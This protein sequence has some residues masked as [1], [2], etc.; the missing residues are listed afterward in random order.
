MLFGKS[1]RGSAAQGANNQ[2]SNKDGFT[3]VEGPDLKSRLDSAIKAGRASSHEKFW[4]GYSIDLAQGVAVDVTVT[5]PDGPSSYFPWLQ[6]MKEPTNGY[7]TRN[8]GVFV[9]FDAA[10][11]S[12]KQAKVYNTDMQHNF[13][14]LPVYWLG[15]PDANESLEMLNSLIS[16]GE[17]NAGRTSLVDAIA[18]HRTHRI[19]PL[20]YGLLHTSPYMEVRAS[21]AGWLDLVPQARFVQDEEQKRNYM[22]RAA[23]VV[24][25]NSD[26]ADSPFALRRLYRNAK[27]DQ[28]K[29]EIIERSYDRRNQKQWVGFLLDIAQD[30]KDLAF[31]KLILSYIGKVAGE[32]GP[33]RS[34]NKQNM[35]NLSVEQVRTLGRTE[36]IS[37]LIEIASTD[38]DE[39]IRQ[40]AI[41]ELSKIPDNRVVDFF[42]EFLSR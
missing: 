24:L 40:T 7:E 16:S 42:R 32:R 33:G 30:E 9:L 14:G 6:N 5:S 36:A 2:T 29:R 1:R 26:K 27:D 28:L 3:L 19:I 12:V 10:G 31:K 23:Y 17:D 11:K 38:G 15:K 18:L 25:N 34:P 21:A 37:R 39:R 22:K 13:D 20:L 35:S 4:I 8:A 41:E